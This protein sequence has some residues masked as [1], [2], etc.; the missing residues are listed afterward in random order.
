[1]VTDASGNIVEQTGYAPYGEP[2]N[3]AM[4]T[5]KSYIGE[6][7]EPE[8]GLLY[9]NARYMDPV[10]GRFISPDDWDPTQEG[11]GTNRYAYAGNDPVNKADNNGHQA[12]ENSIAEELFDEEL[13][14]WSNIFNSAAEKTADVALPASEAVLE[15][16]T[17]Y[18]DIQGMATAYESGNWTSFTVSV[19]TAAAGMFPAV[20]PAKVAVKG[21]KSGAN[22]VADVPI[23]MGYDTGDIPVRIPGTWAVSDL[24]QALFGHPPRG[25]GSP[26]LHHGGQM[27][28]GAKEETLPSQLRNNPVLHLNPNQGAT[29]E[30]R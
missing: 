26:D 20:K 12:L 29:P 14:L 27:P 5:Q 17:P 1:M 23:G 28:G 19:T 13:Q 11:V 2:T 8:T 10:L 24:K 25:L 22:K 16:L 18:G 6:R 4:T 15:N 21:V 3:Q 9:L 30:M 7:H